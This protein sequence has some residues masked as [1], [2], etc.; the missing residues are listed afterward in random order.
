MWLLFAMCVTSLTAQ[1]AQLIPSL[2]ILL[3]RAVV[4]YSPWQF[5]FLNANK[6]VF[7]LLFEFIL[8]F[9]N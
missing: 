2:L 5:F 6:I 9:F 7:E 8:K 4:I 3:Q 1:M